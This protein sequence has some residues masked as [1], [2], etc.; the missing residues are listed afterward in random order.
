MRQH[1][2]HFVTVGMGGYRETGWMKLDHVPGSVER[3]RALLSALGYEQE[4]DGLAGGG[5][6]TWINEQLGEWRGSGRSLV[7]YWTGHGRIDADKHFLITEDSPD[8][9]GL[10]H[11]NAFPTEG[12]GRILA[13][14]DYEEVLVLIDCCASGAAATRIAAEIASVMDHTTRAGPRRRFA[15]ISSASGYDSAEDGVFAETLER[16]VR[17]GPEDRRWTEHDVLIHS[18]ALAAV[19]HDELEAR[20]GATDYRAVGA[21]VPALR[22]PLHPSASIPDEDVE[23]KRLRRLRAG[24]L[25]QHLVLSARGIE[26]GETGWFFCG[27]EQLIERLVG[28]LK[29]AE[30]GLFVV[31]GSP[32][33]G[34]SA[35]LGRIATLSVPELRAIAES[36]G[37]LTGTPETALPEPDSIDVALSCRNKTLD[38]CLRAI[39]DGLDLPLEEERRRAVDVV[40]E[41]GELGRRVAVVVDGL[42]EATVS[43]AISIAADLLRPLADLP[44]VRVIVGTRP[45]RAGDAAARAR[46]DGPLLRPLKADEIAILDDEPERV[47]DL[48]AYAYR[49]LLEAPG[50]PLRA[51]ERLARSWADRIAEASGGVFL[52]ARVAARAVLNSPDGVGAGPRISSL[53]GSLS[54]VLDQE[55]GR[56]PDPERVRELL[57]P[58][59]WAEGAG[60]PRREVWPLL[61]TALAGSG[62]RYTDRDI[63]WILEHAGFYLV[64]SGEAGQTVYR[65]YHQALIDYFRSR[66]PLDAQLRVTRALLKTADGGGSAAWAQVNPYLRLHLAAHGRASGTLP[67]MVQDS[68]FLAHTHPS[69]TAAAL[70]AVPERFTLPAARLY[71]RVWHRLADLSAEE[72]LRKLHMT[73]WLDEPEALALFD[74]R[75]PIPARVVAASAPSDDFSL[76]LRGHSGPVTAIT[77]VGWPDGRELLASAGG[78]GT[79]RVWDP[80]NGETRLVLTDTPATVTALA[81]LTDTGGRRLLAAGV[82][83]EIYVWDVPEGRLLTVLHGHSGRVLCLTACDSG[84]S[85]VL[86]SSGEDRVIRVWQADI[87]SQ[88]ELTGHFGPVAA[89]AARAL[90]D[91]P[92]VLVSAG[93]DCTVRMW[94]L[95]ALEQIDTLY[96]HTGPVETAVHLGTRD[97]S[98]FAAT[99][100]NDGE[101]RVWD[102]S[103]RTAY[104]AY[105]GRVGRI[106]GMTAFTGSGGEPAWLGA[107]GTHARLSVSD[108]LALAVRGIF[109][110]RSEEVRD[111]D[112]SVPKLGSG[113]QIAVNPEPGKR[114][115]TEPAEELGTSYALAS[116]TSAGS[117]CLASVGWDGMV[118][119]WDPARLGPADQPDYG[120]RRARHIAPLPGGIGER[121]HLVTATG[122]SGVSVIDVLGGGETVLLEGFLPVAALTAFRTPDGAPHVA[123]VEGRSARPL[124]MRVDTGTILEGPKLAIG[125]ARPSLGDPLR[126]H[127]EPALLR[128]HVAPGNAAVLALNQ[129]GYTHVWAWQRAEGANHRQETF[130]FVV[131]CPGDQSDDAVP[132]A[133]RHGDILIAEPTANGTVV[134]H[135]LRGRRRRAAATLTYPTGIRVAPPLPV[136]GPRGEYELAV[137]VRPDSMGEG[138]GIAETQIVLA[139]LYGRRRR[140]TTIPSGHRGDIEHWAVLSRADGPDLIV[141]ACDDGALR[142]WD[143]RS[144]RPD[145]PLVVPLPG[146]PAELAVESPDMVLVLI[147]EHWIALRVH[148]LDA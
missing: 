13:Q 131:P 97:G 124:L 95:D 128:S 129:D 68:G 11:V 89:L 85:P 134:L 36:E 9:G 1:K 144:A 141:G 101:I 48:E 42:D 63:A 46:N 52:Y 87:W 32:G 81:T 51:Q 108:P 84:G 71:L 118:R 59:A 114:G 43:E 73:A 28:W 44:G 19:L 49:R 116:L 57:Y 74:G 146:Q 145:R 121:P 140:S 112:L 109:N 103:K 17:H 39:A 142:I 133:T 105:P 7:L 132:L 111:Q 45:E 66:S 65:L 6:C 69:R 14:R 143:V 2:A 102:L 25:D 98:H 47:R 33:T 123:V 88:S 148:G 127:A 26:V 20:D 29:R 120:K 67:D 3:I 10:S 35:I 23:T 61:A 130:H 54:D 106:R 115:P 27:R 22:N 41:V 38:D 119:L 94:D 86:V 125:T 75:A 92:R 77:T 58:L 12:L 34:K 18:D 126:W 96:G 90:P 16:V 31:T 72:R 138:G 8:S 64:E 93:A 83:Q 55:L 70:L 117:V 147:R 37:A 100:A 56:F 30:R 107:A 21:P 82:E 110:N 136:M 113:R 24:D 104:G 135:T 50:S 122:G 139:Q 137:A 76:S 79:I 60:L 15:V 91:G 4:L 5:K 78:D 40:R 53:A 99:G 62:R 80:D